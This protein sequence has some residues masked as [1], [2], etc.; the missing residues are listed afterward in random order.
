L[1]GNTGTTSKTFSQ[2]SSYISGFLNFNGLRNIYLCSGNLCSMNI[3]GPRGSVHP[4][5]KK[6]PVTSDYGFNIFSGGSISHDYVEASKQ[7]WNVIDLNDSP[8]S[9]SIVLSTILEDL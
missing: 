2:G 7:V 6:V 1:I 4:I 5:I 3:V 8:V 9:F